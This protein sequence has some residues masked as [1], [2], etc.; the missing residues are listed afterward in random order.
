MRV[1]EPREPAAVA[2]ADIAQLPTYDLHEQQL[3][4]TCQH[5]AVA[6]TWLGR[7]ADEMFDRGRPPPCVLIERDRLCVPSCVREGLQVKCAVTHAYA[8][9][10]GHRVEQRTE[11]L[12]RMQEAANKA[13]FLA[14]SP[15]T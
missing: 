3:G 15:V 7:L 2:L 4:Q 10:S 14:A 6:G 11:A 12:V 8:C 13:A 5:R 9:E 1:F